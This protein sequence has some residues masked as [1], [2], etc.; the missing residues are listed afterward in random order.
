[1][2]LYAPAGAWGPRV[3]ACR[4]VGNEFGMKF[5][6]VIRVLTLKRTGSA[7]AHAH[8]TIHA[9]EPLAIWPQRPAGAHAKAITD[10]NLLSLSA[11]DPE[12]MHIL[13][14]DAQSDDDLAGGLGLQP[15]SVR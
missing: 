15:E 10:G 12:P 6:T 11:E 1:M 5:G 2:P 14:H 8:D 3:G 4:D 13:G 9:P 7:R